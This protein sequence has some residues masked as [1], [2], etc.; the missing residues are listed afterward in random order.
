MKNHSI[1]LLSLVVLSASWSLSD[2]A[3]ASF[4][5]MQ[6]EQVIG[7]VN[8]DT[9]AQA[10]QLRMRSGG[11]N[12][13]GSSS[14]RTFDATGVN[15][16]VLFNT[17]STVTNGALGS[18][19]LI[20]TPN[21]ANYT[22]IPLV[23]DFT[24]VPIPVSYLAVGQVTFESLSGTVTYWSLSWGG[25]GFTGSTTANSGITNDDDGDYGPAVDGPLP[26]NSLSAL[27][28]Q[29]IASDKSTT[30]FDDY[31][32]T[33]GAAT[34]TNNAGT[35]FTLVAPFVESANFDGDNDV[36]GEDF[37]I[38]QRF[39]G[40]PGGLSQGDANNDGNVDED[41]LAIWEAQYGLP[42]TL[43]GV[44]AIPEPQSICL[45]LCGLLA[46]RRSAE[47]KLPAARSLWL[48]SDVVFWQRD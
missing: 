36:D 37:L 28:F 16:V 18:R 32:L 6:I 29:G 7:G 13:I 38:W 33:S 30:N 26:S 39:A 20:T 27:L 1:R 40:G 12:F 11:Q 42:V 41:D 15:E 17:G 47:I 21:F 34:F 14:L 4:H 31:A 46:L 25:S 5:I 35:A 8:G 23:S 43:S 3:S 24:M 45:L 19:V 48:D 10:I 22:D 2:Q 9:T 44:S